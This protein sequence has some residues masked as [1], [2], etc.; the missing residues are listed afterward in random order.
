MSASQVKALQTKIGVNPD[1]AFGAGSRAALRAHVIKQ[2]S[3]S[4]RLGKEADAKV[5]E[6][7]ANAELAK[8]RAEQARAEAARARVQQLKQKRLADQAEANRAGLIRIGSIGAG[9]A[10]AAGTDYAVTKFIGHSADARNAALAGEAKKLQGLIP[11][12]GK[13]ATKSGQR[14]AAKALAIVN[15]NKHLL[16]GRG[17]GGFVVAGVL[18]GKAALEFGLATQYEEGR[19]E[20]TILN[21][22]ATAGTT[23]ALLVSGG[24]TFRRSQ[25]QKFIQPG[26]RSAFAQ[27]E[28][29][30]K[31]AAASA[32]AQQGANLSKAAQPVGSISTPGRGATGPTHVEL[33]ARAKASGISG[34]S[35]M[36]KSVLIAQLEKTGANVKLPSVV[37]QSSLVSRL[38]R[39]AVKVVGKSLSPLALGLA[40]LAGWAAYSEAKASGRSRLGSSAVGVGTA[41]DNFIGSPVEGTRSLARAISDNNRNFKKVTFSAADLS[42]IKLTS[43]PRPSFAAANA[44]FGAKRA[45]RQ[46]STATGTVAAHTRRS[47]T[48]THSTSTAVQ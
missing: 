4:T 29:L 38:A 39:G 1:G 23:T 35:R 25:P 20:K 45:T 10:I 47:G 26:I 3:E 40:G 19:I 33:R 24:E 44:A 27:A 9:M 31:P 12:L 5:Q 41:M 22:A 37:T 32:A 30:A 8:A 21:A 18:A 36:R 28:T 15:A 11:E 42:G 2:R 43:A 7:R 46:A 6:Q 17:P 34:A 14:A 48:R 16:R 13:P